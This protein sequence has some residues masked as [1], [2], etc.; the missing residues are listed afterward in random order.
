MG[1]TTLTMSINVWHTLDKMYA[2]RSRARSVNTCITLATTKKGASTMIEFYSK[3]KSYANEMTVSGQP[4]GDEEFVAYV[5]TGLDEE[6][7]NSFVSSIVTRV[8]P[9]APAELYSQILA[10]ELRFMQQA[11][12]TSYNSAS[13]AN[14][15]SRGHGPSWTR[16]GSPS[17]GRGRFFGSGRGSS[18]RRSRGG[19]NTK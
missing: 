18:P 12:H 16:G 3:M 1:V 4:L 5:L 9:I 7:Y 17:R 10:F 2:N 6:I 13:F 11:A 19:Y 14:T 8:E 15:V